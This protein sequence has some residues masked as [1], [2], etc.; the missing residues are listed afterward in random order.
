M[1]SVPGHDDSGFHQVR[2]PTSSSPSIGSRR[3]GS[4]ARCSR[5]A[6]ARCDPGRPPGSQR[7]GR[8]VGIGKRGRPRGGNDD[9]RTTTAGPATSQRRLRW[10]SAS[11]SGVFG[12]RAPGGP[13]T[14]ARPG[15]RGWGADVRARPRSTG[16]LCR[17]QARDRTG[18]RDIVPMW[19]AKAR[20][21]PRRRRGSG[22]IME[23]LPSAPSGACRRRSRSA[24]GRP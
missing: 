6:R 10:S 2:S 23:A 13:S 9:A 18:V 20:A 5:R 14:I 24:R 21:I 11:S 16:P 17:R 8:T 12:P 1:A 4:A 3:F 19:D 7:P 15:A 22:P